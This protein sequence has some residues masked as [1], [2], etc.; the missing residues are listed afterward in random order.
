MLDFA[1]ILI[2][3]LMG[4]LSDTAITALI[5]AIPP[6][7]VALTGLVVSLRNSSKADK[8]IQNTDTVVHK[9]EE[10]H[11]LTNSQ[12]TS[13]TAKLQEA[14]D[15]I[16]KLERLIPTSL[17]EALESKGSRRRRGGDRA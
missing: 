16:V 5:V 7:I 13:V 2:N 15:H 4:L 10:I 14:N 6:T 3:T 11:D 1:A 12:L 8:V 9:T 17:L